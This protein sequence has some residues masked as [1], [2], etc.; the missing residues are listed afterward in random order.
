MSLFIGKDNSNK[1]CMVLSKTLKTEATIKASSPDL[2]NNYALDTRRRLMY[3]TLFS[4]SAYV[5][6][7]YLVNGIKVYKT[8]VNIDPS[9]IGNGDTKKVFLVYTDNY[10]NHIGYE[11]FNPS[12]GYLALSFILYYFGGSYIDV[13][14]AR[15]IPSSIQVIVFD[16]YANGTLPTL[17][18]NNEISILGSSLVVN[19]I[20]YFN[21]PFLVYPA[22][23]S[24]D[25]VINIWGLNIQIINSTA[26]SDP[27][28]IITDTDNNS[29]VIAKG[30]KLLYSSL[31]N[32]PQM[33]ALNQGYTTIPFSIYI[34]Y[35]DKIIPIVTLD[36]TSKYILAS[37]FGG[38]EYTTPS[39]IS[40]YSNQSIPLGVDSYPI[41]GSGGEDTSGFVT[42]SVVV[43]GNTLYLVITYEHDGEPSSYHR[44]LQWYFKYLV[45]G[46]TN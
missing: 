5:V 34:D 46:S 23:N 20:D 24:Y 31:L 8:R 10:S 45:I 37:I 30:P 41:I 42:Y 33:Y 28:H 12:P 4:G 39:I 36:S 17:D 21:R 29:I 38:G 7:S 11:T 3:C 27:L 19:G 13:I 25:K 40:T 18:T 22:I 14:G 15:Y 9:I 43:S 26:S 32:Y 2:S 6:T 1:S 16:Y 44:T 35:I